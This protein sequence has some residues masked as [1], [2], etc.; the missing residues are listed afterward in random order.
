MKKA[1][2][3]F[4]LVVASGLNVSTTFASGGDTVRLSPRYKTFAASDTGDTIYTWAWRDPVDSIVSVINGKIGDINI[5]AN[6]I[7][8]PSKIDSTKPFIMRKG[9]FDTIYVDTLK[10]RAIKYSGT[11]LGDSLKITRLAIIDSISARTIAQKDTTNKL[12]IWS[13]RIKGTGIITCDSSYTHH[14]TGVITCDS[15]FAR[16]ATAPTIESIYSNSYSITAEHAKITSIDTL[17]NLIYANHINAVRIDDTIL[18][19][20][21]IR[22]R[23]LRPD[24]LFL[25]CLKSDSLHTGIINSGNTAVKLKISADSIYTRAMKADSLFLT[26]VNS[27]ASYIYKLKSD[28]LHTGIIN[29]GD[30]ASIKLKISADSIYTR[31]INTQGGKFVLGYPASQLGTYKFD[32]VKYNIVNKNVI[33]NFSGVMGVGSG[34]DSSIFKTDSLIPTAIRPSDSISIPITAV[35][36][37]WKL[38]NAV[39][40]SNGKVNFFKGLYATTGNDCYVVLKG[41]A[42][43]WATES[44]GGTKG[45]RPFT[46]MYYLK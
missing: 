18:N 5:S 45:Y 1:W 25:N 16:I 21:S 30:T 35:D 14:G 31:Q 43:Y 4:V 9:L 42:A 8:N 23:S 2:L 24:S 12:T 22:V 46:F 44:G 27:F 15:S 29:S 3:L 32:T 40:S 7:I 20:D 6:A 38:A 19:A 28:S 33:L 10:A 41:A 17:W 39:I 34:S 26:N 37:G 36:I 13:P 11:L